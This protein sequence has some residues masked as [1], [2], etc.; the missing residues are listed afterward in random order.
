MKFNA[1]LY[2]RKLKYFFFICFFILVIYLILRVLV[3]DSD[4]I[5]PLAT[6]LLDTYLLL[7][8][9]F[10]NQL[11]QWTG[12]EAS[13]KNHLVF[14]SGVQQSG[15][16]PEI[17]LKK[18]SLILI[19]LIWITRAPN[20]S[21][22]FFTL[23]SIVIHYFF[24]SYYIA[25]GIYQTIAGNYDEYIPALPLGIGNITLLSILLIWYKINKTSVLDTFTIVRLD[26]D[27]RK[28]K[29][30]AIFAVFYLYIIVVQIVPNFIDFYLWVLLL[31]KS[32]Q[33]ILGLMGINSSIEPFHLVGTNGSL[34]I[35]QGCLGL[36]TMFLFAAIVFLTGNQTK[37]RLIF[38]TGGL[39][40]LTLV[41]NLRLVFLFKLVQK[42]GDDMIKINHFHDLYTYIVYFIIF[43][44]WVIWFEKFSYLRI[45]GKTEP[46]K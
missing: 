6:S 29:A 9:K 5:I 38:I 21:K 12:S 7:A 41:N 13:I 42:F 45:K 26:K 25:F 20:R 37:N 14:V 44:L 8:E 36:K 3:F 22:I 16:N 27:L 31:S 28:K 2:N 23:L 39:I 32:S 18:S 17:V 40:F 35:N 34:Y 46:K 43:I 1:I 11:L 4:P 10:A 19:F 33:F 30:D 24:V 15:F